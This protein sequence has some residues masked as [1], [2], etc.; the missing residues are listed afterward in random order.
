MFSSYLTRRFILNLGLCRMF[1]INGY[2]SKKK[3]RR[4]VVLGLLADFIRYITYSSLIFLIRKQV[5][6]HEE[7]E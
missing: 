4:L 2:Y 3:A 1:I 5:P 7:N 6:E